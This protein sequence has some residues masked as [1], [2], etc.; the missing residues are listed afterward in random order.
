MNSGESGWSAL[1]YYCPAVVCRSCSY[2]P[3]LQRVS[4]R[5]P[6]PAAWLPQHRGETRN[7]GHLHGKMS[8]PPFSPLLHCQEAV[9][10]DRQPQ[11]A[12]VLESGVLLGHNYL[13]PSLLPFS[14]SSFLTVVFPP[15]FF[16]L[17]FFFSL[18]HSSLWSESEVW[19]GNPP[20]RLVQHPSQTAR[21]CSLPPPACFVLLCCCQ[22]VSWIRVCSSLWAQEGLVA[23]QD[24]LP[25][26]WS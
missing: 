22:L 15:L 17:H 10:P 19:V 7:W 9:P 13:L 16:F 21:I 18:F 23:W 14:P 6:Q 25:D 26:H 2:C 5:G 4:K 11:A 3:R 24:F 1:R 20:Q 8:L 12:G